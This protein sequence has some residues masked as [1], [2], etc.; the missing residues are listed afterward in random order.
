[1]TLL[2]HTRSHHRKKTAGPQ[3]TL[4]SLLTRLF[5][6]LQQTYPEQELLR[7]IY[8]GGVQPEIRRAVW[9]FLLGHYQFGMTE[10]ERKEVGHLSPVRAMKGAGCC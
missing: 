3:V 1:M 4:A 2:I 10:L 9:P 7:L 8:Y 6:S 5:A